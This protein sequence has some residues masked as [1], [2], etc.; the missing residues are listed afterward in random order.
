MND[1]LSVHFLRAD[2]LAAVSVDV[3][4]FFVFCFLICIVFI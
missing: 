2:G 3:S 1:L 4:L